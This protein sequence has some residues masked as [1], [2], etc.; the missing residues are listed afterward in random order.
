MR[1]KISYEWVF[2]E[3]DNNG[4]IIDPL[5]SDKLIDAQREAEGC[6]TH[7][8]EIALVRNEGTEEDGL[9][10]REYAYITAEGELPEEFDDGY[11]VPQRFHKELARGG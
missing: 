3:Y 10:V 9:Q 5:F 11:K 6:F 2:E 4:D 1:N 7:E 8:Y